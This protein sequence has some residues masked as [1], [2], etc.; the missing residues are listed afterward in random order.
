MV[1]LGPVGPGYVEMTSRAEAAI[2][3]TIDLSKKSM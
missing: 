3:G 1:G 2:G